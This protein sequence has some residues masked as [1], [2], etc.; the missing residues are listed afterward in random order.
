MRS[1]VALA[2]WL[3]AGPALA[4]PPPTVV[5]AGGGVM[6]LDPPDVLGS[7]PRELVVR[8]VRVHAEE[9]IA[10]VPAGAE[11]TVTLRLRV[12]YPGMVEEV[13]DL[14]AS[15]TSRRLTTCLRRAIERWVFPHHFLSVIQ[16]RM[17]LTGRPPSRRE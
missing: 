8:I 10:C 17:V 5:R 6:A 15:P 4:Q 11:H 1:L 2:V 9:L 14:K 3:A 7:P 13:A 12:S 16:L